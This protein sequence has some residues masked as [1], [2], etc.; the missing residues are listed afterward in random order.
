MAKFIKILVGK[1]DLSV[2]FNLEALESID[3]KNKRVYTIGAS[4]SYHIYN[5]ESW[6]KIIN[7]VESNMYE[8]VRK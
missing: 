1:N 8:S 3:Y 4:E 5:Q 2:A 7:Y 6:D